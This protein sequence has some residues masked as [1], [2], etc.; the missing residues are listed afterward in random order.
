MLERDTRSRVVSDSYEQSFAGTRRGRN[1][2]E[3]DS[4]PAHAFAREEA[5][6]CRGELAPECLGGSRGAGAWGERQPGVFLAQAVSTRP[7]R[8]DEATGGTAARADCC[9]GWPAD[10]ACS[11]RPC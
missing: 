3:H 11:D 5:P 2:T 7:A 6:H 10:P 1:E 9:S 8:T 4:A